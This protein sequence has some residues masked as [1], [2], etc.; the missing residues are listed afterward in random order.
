VLIGTAILVVVLPGCVEVKDSTKVS[1]GT[2]SSSPTGE[3]FKDKLSESEP[4]RVVT[5][6]N[7]LRDWVENVGGDRVQV[8]SIVPD[9]VDPHTFR[10]SPKEMKYLE[11]A[12]M[13]FLVGQNYEEHW[14]GSLSHN[15]VRGASKI[16]YLSESVELRPYSR[17]SG[18]I[19]GAET[20]A[21]TYE[22][23][24]SYENLEEYDPHFWHDPL[25]VVGAINRIAFELNGMTLTENSD[26]E[27]QAESYIAKLEKLNRWIVSQV[28]KIPNERRVLITSHETM[29]YFAER[30]DFEIADSMMSG[31]SSAESVNPRQIAGI[32]D[33]IEEME[34]ETV[35]GEPQM[36]DKVANAVSGDTG[37][38]FVY[39]N[40]ESIGNAEGGVA[41]DYIEMMKLNVKTIV[42]GLSR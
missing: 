20:T 25:R 36:S 32:I 31:L 23:E 27:S 2:Q 30:Y 26:F 34:I 12:H 17:R 22:V 15:V 16:V 4:I 8:Y 40:S 3:G 41:A 35:F 1:E 18:S 11:Q 39:L 6:T 42:N 5:T 38:R 28:A 19:G 37:V 7:I 14:L 9:A 24:N 21:S 33:K 13:V 29:G 10:P